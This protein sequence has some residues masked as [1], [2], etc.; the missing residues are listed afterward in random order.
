MTTLNEPF[1]MSLKKNLPSESA[2]APKLSA[3]IVI[4]APGR[5]AAGSPSVTTLPRNTDCAPA[6]E[7]RHVTILIWIQPRKVLFTPPPLP[8]ASRYFTTST[9][10][11]PLVVLVKVYVPG[12]ANNRDCASLPT[13]VGGFVTGTVP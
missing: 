1:G 3:G 11:A 10:L 8:S 2:R 7:E 12:V 6:A 9:A 5:G 4:S 13:G